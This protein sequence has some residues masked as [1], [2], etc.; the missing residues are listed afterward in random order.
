MERN[1]EEDLP[2]EGKISRFDDFVLCSFALS[3][4]S[5][6]RF[7]EGKIT[8]TTIAECFNAKVES[9]GSVNTAGK[10]VTESGTT[11]RAHVTS[12]N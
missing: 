9:N 5:R 2:V 7:E 3:F 11:S 12:S 1:Q 6:R 4:L 8:T 10:T